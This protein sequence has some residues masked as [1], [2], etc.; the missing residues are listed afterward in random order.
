MCGRFLLAIKNTETN[1]PAY[2]ARFVMQGH[3]DND[4]DHI[5]NNANIIRQHSIRIIGTIA[6]V[7]GFRIWSQDVAQA[8]LQAGEKLMRK[9]YLQAP[10]KLQL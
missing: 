4:K 10:G 3:M 6:G 8:N 2:K 1:Q 5:V 9:V 7:F